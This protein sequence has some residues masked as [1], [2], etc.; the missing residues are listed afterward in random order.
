MSDPLET[1]L[2]T[3]VNP[4]DDSPIFDDSSDD[5]DMESY[6]EYKT[7]ARDTGKELRENY[8]KM[9]AKQE[10]EKAK[11]KAEKAVAKEIKKKKKNKTKKKP[12]SIEMTT[13]T[14]NQ[15]AGKRKR[16]TRKRRTKKRRKRGGMEKE[17]EKTGEEAAFMKLG[18]AVQKEKSKIVKEIHSPAVPTTLKKVQPIPGVARP[19]R[20]GKRKRKR[21][22]RKKR[23]VKRRLTKKRR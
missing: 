6:T 1:A 18:R 12:M 21:K 10:K 5:S 13:I 15:K 2:K 14:T 7:K 20:G 8:F 17:S 19:T 23:K 3:G 11:A 9:K 4:G 16:K 22:T